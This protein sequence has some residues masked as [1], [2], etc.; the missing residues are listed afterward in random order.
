[1]LLKTAIHKAS[2]MSSVANVQTLLELGASPNYKDP[3][4][5]TPLYYNM[6]TTDSKPD[7]TEMLLKDAADLSIVDMHGN[8][9]LHQ[10]SFSYT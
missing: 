4:G 5:L 10:A 1:M 6:L 9:E 8:Y 7:V 2:F 3:L